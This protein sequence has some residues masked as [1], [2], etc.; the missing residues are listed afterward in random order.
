LINHLRDPMYKSIIG[1]LN[2]GI[3]EL[4]H[5]V[6]SFMGEFITV[7]AGSFVQCLV[8]L[9]GILNF[10]RVRDFFAITFCLGWLSTNFF[11]VATYAADAKDMVLPLVGLGDGLIIHD[12]NYLLTNLG[13]L[14]QCASI[15]FLFRLM[16]LFS[17]LACLYLG[18]WLI[19]QMFLTRN[20]P[21]EPFSQKW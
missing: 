9:L 1:P 11:E 18:S 3:H 5:V 20:E 2:L 14:K 7:A 6:F 15:A 8:P 10:Y 13:L 4:A 16:G 19:Y 21:K 17:M 12:W